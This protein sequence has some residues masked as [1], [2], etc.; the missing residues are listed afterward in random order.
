MLTKTRNSLG[1]RVRELEY[2][3][4]NTQR[5]LEDEMKL[6]EASR[7]SDD[8]KERVFNL[9]IEKLKSDNE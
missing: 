8:E 4:Q 7:G 6:K 1:H 9:R 2:E 5:A 3:L